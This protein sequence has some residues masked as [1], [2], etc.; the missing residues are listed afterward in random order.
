MAI[1][2][3]KK[4]IALI[5]EAC[6]ITDAIFKKMIGDFKFTTEQELADFI[7]KEIK[8]RKLR[9][10]FPPIVAAGKNASEPHHVPRPSVL[11]GFIVIDFGVVYKKYMSDMTRTIYVGTPSK[12][13]R[14][15]YKLVLMA[16]E[17]GIRGVH[18]GC[19]SASVGVN[20]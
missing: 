2:K 11:K 19:R 20:Q 16:E 5:T 7:K 9:P 17:K 6:K 1:I 4:E 18:I 3:T 13:E 14:E 8:E 12:K 10:S 15:M